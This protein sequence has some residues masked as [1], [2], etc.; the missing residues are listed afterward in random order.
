[1]ARELQCTASA[2]CTI[3]IDIADMLEIIFNDETQP[4][5]TGIFFD[6]SSHIHPCGSSR[7]SPL[8]RI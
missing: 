3:F 6:T 1:M 4:L 5:F 7:P 2:G 8:Q